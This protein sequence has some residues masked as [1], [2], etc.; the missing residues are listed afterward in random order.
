M[1]P[2]KMR[3]P[4]QRGWQSMRV[5]LSLLV[6]ALL[7]VASPIP[8]TAQDGGPHG[9]RT[10]LDVQGAVGVNSLFLPLIQSN[11]QLPPPVT[12][13]QPG[14]WLGTGSRF[15]IHFSVSW[16]GSTCQATA[17]TY[18]LSVTCRTPDGASWTFYV[19]DDHLQNASIAASQFSTKDTHLTTTVK[20][21]FSSTTAVAGTWSYYHFN[22]SN[23]ATCKGAGNWMGSPEP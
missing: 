7:M 18:S 2:A 13:P 20:G 14:R 5:L 22:P 12:C 4:G 15:D 19:I 10:R 11:G 23:L 1:K 17:M 21:T 6:T 9:S 16:D 3:L 8:T